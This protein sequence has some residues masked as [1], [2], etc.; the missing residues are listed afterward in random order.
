MNWF[1]AR[2]DILH[3]PSMKEET[4]T[5]TT[6]K[7]DFQQNIAYLVRLAPNAPDQNKKNRTLKLQQR[8]RFELPKEARSFE[9]S[10]EGKMLYY[11]RAGVEGTVSQGVRAFGLRRTRYLGLPKAHLQH[12]AT[13]AAINLDR[14]VA[15]FNG[16]TRAQTRTSRFA[17]LAPT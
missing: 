16:L 15:W 6:S 13:A 8:P 2:K 7:S 11:K 5:D 10:E 14:I 4:S 3:T 1:D 12:I 9:E 17:A